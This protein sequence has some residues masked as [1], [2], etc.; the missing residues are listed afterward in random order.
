[1]KRC[2]TC[3]HWS[4]QTPKSKYGECLNKYV[5]NNWEIRADLDNHPLA[6]SELITHKLFGC[7]KH[8]VK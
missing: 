2:V 1:M 5:E 4:R 3:K 7:I 6:S 8:K